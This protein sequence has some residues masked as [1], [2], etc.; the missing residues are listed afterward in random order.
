MN[1]KN[2]IYELVDNRIQKYAPKIK[3]TKVKS[4]FDDYEAKAELKRLQRDFVIVP[5]DKAAN[6]VNNT[7]QILFFQNLTIVKFYLLHPLPI[8][9]SLSQNHQ[10]K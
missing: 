3:S 5:I 6:N 4:V 7:M 2:S 1:W 10:Q 9:M 8:L